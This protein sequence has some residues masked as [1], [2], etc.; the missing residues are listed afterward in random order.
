MNPTARRR[1]LW[2]I[3]VAVSLPMFMA[4]LDNLVVTNALPVI[5]TEL[6]ASLE[7]LSWV[8]NSYTLSFAA[9]IPLAVAVADRCGRRRVFGLGLALFVLAS[10]GCALSGATGLLVSA[11]AVQGAGAAAIMPLSLTLLSTSV[12]ARLRPAAIGIWGGIS[13]LGIALGPLVGGAV[14]EGLSW[15]V[16]FWLNVPLGLACLPLIRFAL[17]ESRGGPAR[18]DFAGILLSG[19]GVLAV[20]YGVVRGNSAGWG[21]TEVLVSLLGGAVLLGWFVWWERRSAAPLIPLRLFRNRSFAVATLVG[22]MFS[23]GVFGSVF[24]LIQFLQLVQGASPLAAGMMTTPWT[25]APLVIAPLTGLVTPRIGTRPVVVAGLVCVTIGL[26]RT[27]AVLHPDVAYG[28]LAPLLALSGLGMGLV[29]APL[30]TAVLAGISQ[31]D[32]AVASGTNSAAREVGVALG[33]ALLSAVFLAGGGTLTPGGFTTAAIP[34]VQLGAAVLAAA[35]LAALALPGLRRTLPPTMKR[36]RA[37]GPLV[38][39]GR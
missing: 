9:L 25:L 29:F 32:Q 6:G 23:L 1:P 38:T 20:V 16:I 18:T 28:T 19:L 21:S 7:Q 15:Q 34:A 13:G 24:I 27:A 8:V 36:P 11:R 5:R 31:E 2:L 14:V 35:S 33:I 17:P 3:M 26:F 30:S 39:P 22:A 4:A 10:I 12:P 37:Q